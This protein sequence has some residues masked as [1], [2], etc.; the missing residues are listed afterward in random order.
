MKTLF[1]GALALLL[2]HTPVQADRPLTVVNYTAFPDREVEQLVKAGVGQMDGTGVLV[3]VKPMPNWVKTG[4]GI[5]GRTFY[6]VPKWVAPNGA[7]GY[8]LFVTV[9]LDPKRFPTTNWAR[10]QI[11]GKLRRMAY[12]GPNSPLI[13]CR[14]WQEGLLASTAH[15]FGHIKQFRNN[16]WQPGLEREAICERRGL[17]ILNQYRQDWPVRRLAASSSK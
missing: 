7:P 6:A 9:A 12:G 5:Q 11:N 15:E 8:S 13:T 17:A 14:T 16:Y 2:F 3:H 1:Y 10:Y 4:W